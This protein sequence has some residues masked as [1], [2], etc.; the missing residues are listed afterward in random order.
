[1]SLTARELIATLEGMDPDAQIEFE[2]PKKNPFGYPGITEGARVIV[3]SVKE[4]WY[5]TRSNKWI[6]LSMESEKEQGK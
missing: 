4:V 6:V 1:M 2:V 5:N 3:G